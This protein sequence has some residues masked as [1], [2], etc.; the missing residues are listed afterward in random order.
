M[1]KSKSEFKFSII[2]IVSFIWL[3]VDVLIF[4]NS[5]IVELKVLTFQDKY[6]KKNLLRIEKTER[7]NSN[8]YVN[9]E[10]DNFSIYGKLLLGTDT[11][12]NYNL[13]WGVSENPWDAIKDSISKEEGSFQF[14][15]VLVNSEYHLI[16][17]ANDD[18]FIQ[19][20]I[21]ITSLFIIFYS[22]PFW[23]FPYFYIKSYL[24]KKR[25]HEKNK[26]V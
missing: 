16:Y 4:S 1:R 23:F 11:S 7:W 3:I 12:T 20:Q 26:A 25:K 8:S 5:P 6:L 10:V 2:S 9:H 13:M 24:R 21:L 15:E 19:R 22:I 14:V 18:S 17:P